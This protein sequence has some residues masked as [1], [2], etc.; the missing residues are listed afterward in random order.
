MEADPVVLVTRP[1]G[2]AGD[3]CRAL[4]D[5]GFVTHHQPLLQ[6]EPLAE[7][8]ARARQ[9]VND[10][11]RYRHVI[12]ISANAVRFGMAHIDE[13]W[14]R[15]PAGILWYAIGD[16]TAALLA[17][18]GLEP[19][20]PGVGMNS[21]GL[22]AL[23]QLAQVDGQRVLIVKGA[24]GRGTLRDVLTDRGARVDELICYRRACPAVDPEQLASRLQEWKVDFILISS[25]EGLQNLLALLRNLE[26]TK[27]RDIAFVV[28]SARVEK[29]AREAG[30]KRI[31]TAANASDEAMLRALQHWRSGE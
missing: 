11:D 30:I 23:P 27:F 25:G 19:I 2:Q 7:L 31:K 24:G 13:A 21:E 28:P 22:L 15:L 17:G 18:K 6:L 16:R 26:T 12:F 14:P 8:P 5:A 9:R 10:L 4:A 20:T 3:L 29:M 1:A